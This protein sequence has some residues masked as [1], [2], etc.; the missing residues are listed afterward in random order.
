MKKTI[1]LA[2]LVSPALC[3]NTQP[4]GGI[5][6]VRLLNGT[7]DSPG[8]AEKVTLL[9]LGTEMQ[10]IQELA[11]V[12]GK[13]QMTNIVVEGERPLLLQVTSGGVN[14]NEPVRFGR[15]YEAEVEVTVF[16]TSTNWEHESISITTSRFLYR[17]EN[18]SL[19]VDK[20]F[21]VD[22]RTSPPR[23]Y[24]HPEGTF[25][26]NLPSDKLQELHSI[27]ASGALGVPVPQ[28]ANP[29]PDGSGFIT[30]TAFKPGETQISISYEVNYENTTYE[31]RGI[32]FYPLQELL[33]FIAPSD[34]AT[35][36][37]GWEKLGIEPEGRFSAL[38]MNSVEPGTPFSFTLSGGSRIAE[39]LISSSEDSSRQN[40]SSEA[41][42]TRITDNTRASKWV[43]VALMAAALCYGLLTKLLPTSVNRG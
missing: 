29:L 2:M 7:N 5:L 34:I 10:P 23:T 35:D 43:I 19:L 6:T 13:F 25:R 12:S 24:Y 28:Q 37:P 40:P 18:E 36:A 1:L 14:Y 20:V 3:A 21:V 32:A 9:R 15:G 42:V 4:Q 41:T 38:R 31:A 17:R 11:D 22:N 16:D 26:F 30:K 39:P 33:V 27:S 8:A